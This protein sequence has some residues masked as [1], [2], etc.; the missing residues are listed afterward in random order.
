MT[1]RDEVE[2]LLPEMNGRVCV[3]VE[4]F[5]DPYLVRLE[6]LHTEENGVRGVIVWADPAPRPEPWSD[7]FFATWDLLYVEPRYWQVMYANVRFVFDP[8]AIARAQAG[9]YGWLPGYFDDFGDEEAPDAEPG[10]APDPA[11]DVGSGGS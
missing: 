3:A 11:R 5:A 2:Q 6:Q 8:A 4:G 7:S 10:P 9:D 1:P